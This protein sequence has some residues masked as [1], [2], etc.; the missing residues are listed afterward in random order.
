MLYFPHR[1]PHSTYYFPLL[2]ALS[3]ICQLE[4]DRYYDDNLPFNKEI[5]RI[6]VKITQNTGQRGCLDLSRSEV[7]EMYF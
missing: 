5:R 6:N 2:W 7:A 4:Q 1:I 3:R